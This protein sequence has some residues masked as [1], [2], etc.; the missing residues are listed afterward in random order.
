MEML[1]VALT[2]STYDFEPVHVSPRREG[3]GSRAAAPCVPLALKRATPAGPV[4]VS[5]G[6]SAAW[7]R[8]GLGLPAT[9]SSQSPLWSAS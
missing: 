6:S 7:R 4:K 9:V 1:P 3:E 5:V 8:I 2:V